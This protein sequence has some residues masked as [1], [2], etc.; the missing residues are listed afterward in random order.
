LLFVSDLLWMDGWMD[1]EEVY[2]EV[3]LADGTYLLRSPAQSALSSTCR[4]IN[5]G[6]LD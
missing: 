6:W 1:G 3:W 2:A 5:F 4:I